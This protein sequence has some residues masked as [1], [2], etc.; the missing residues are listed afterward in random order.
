MVKGIPAVS[1]QRFIEAHNDMVLRGFLGLEGPHA[2][3]TFCT[4]LQVIEEN[5]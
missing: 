3:D 4:L 2:L 5:S 1:Q